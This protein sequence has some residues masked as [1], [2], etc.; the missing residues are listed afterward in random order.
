MLG[1]SA[2]KAA[3]LQVQTSNLTVNAHHLTGN[4]IPQ[5]LLVETLSTSLH[6]SSG[7]VVCQALKLVT[8]QHSVLQGN[9]LVTYDTST[10]L[11]TLYDSVRITA[12]LSESIIASADLGIFIPYFTIYK[13]SYRF[14]G[15]IEGKLDDLHLKNFKFDL[16]DSG[17]FL[18]GNL[19]LQGLP[20]LK[21]TV[22]NLELQEGHLQVQELLP[23]LDPKHHHLL[24]G[25]VYISPQGHIYG[26]RDD[27]TACTTFSTA[28]GRVST[29]LKFQID[30]GSQLA[31]YKGALAT[32][33][34]ELGKWL[35]S[36]A[37][38]QL[39]MQGQID[40]QGMS[41]D[42]ADFQ[43]EAT[44]DKLGWNNY[45]YQNMN[46]QGAFTQTSFEGKF[47]VNDPNLQCQ[48]DA[49]IDLN[50]SQ[51]RIAV[52][53]AIAR[54]D[55]QALRLTAVP[56]TFNT[57]LSMKLQGLLLDNSQVD[58]QLNGLCLSL[59][60][61]QVDLGA[62]HFRAGQN[63]GKR[64]LALDSSLVALDA[65]GGF[66]YSA[67][68][69]D[70]EHLAQSFQRQFIGD[71]AIPR[72]KRGSPYACAYHI[73]C[74]NINP[75]LS[76]LKPAVYV[77]PGT[78]LEGSFVQGHSST[79][80]LKMTEASSLAF[81]KYTSTDAQLTL[82]AK[83][84]D[85]D[86]S[87]TVQ[88]AARQQQWGTLSTTEEFT[89]DVSWI[90]DR[91]NFGT[92]LVQTGIP[93]QLQLQGRAILLGTTVAL[94]LD[95]ASI[96]LFNQKW[97]IHPQNRITLGKNWTQFRKFEWTS[98]TQQISINGI[99]IADPN[100]VLHVK[101]KNFA[102]DNLNSL[103]SK[104]L[105][106]ALNATAVLRGTLG[107]SHIDSDIS[108]D[109]LTIDS[110][111]IGDFQAKTNWKDSLKRLRLVGQL[112]YSAQQ[113][114]AIQG[115]YE[116]EKEEDSL[117]LVAHLFQAQLAALGP[118][119]KQEFSQL[120]GE[121]TG[122]L[123]ISGSLTSPR[124]TGTASIKNATVKINYLQALYQAQ[125]EL[126]FAD[127]FINVN[128]LNLIDDQQGRA[129]LRGQLAFKDF[130]ELQLDLRG[131]MTRFK[132]L[133]TSSED[134]K[135]FYG[136]SIASGK[137][138]FS[139]P[140]NQLTI[141]IRARTEAGTSIGIPIGK[142][143]NSVPQADFIRFVNDQGEHQA[144]KKPQAAFM[145]VK[146]SMLL[147]I[148]PDA[149]IDIMLN[150]GGQDTIKGRGRGQLKM[151]ADNQGVLSMAGGFEFSEGAY[152]FSLYQ[153]VNKTFTILP[154]SKITWADKPF[155][156]VLDVKA[157]YD[158][159]VAL[160]PLL[161]TRQG[162]TT[163]K[164]PVQVLVALRGTLLSPDMNFQVNFQEYPSNIAV[165]TAISAFRQR[166]TDRLYLEQQVMSLIIFKRFSEDSLAVTGSGTVSR[167]LGELI[168]K[169]LNNL[170]AGLDENLEIETD[171]DL[172]E[173]F[174]G[175]RF[176][177]SRNFL[178]GRLRVSREGGLGIDAE[179]QTNTARILGDWAVEYL[180][181]PDGRLRAK[182]YN[183]QF[184]SSAYVGA[185]RS[186][187]AASGGVSILY[188]RSF[189]HFPG[190][191]IKQWRKWIF[192]D[193]HKEAAGSS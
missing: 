169:Q 160:T 177:L 67:L 19:H 99:L 56:L 170:V 61:K 145:G 120:T 122:K 147:D 40:G 117:Q 9:C 46:V 45:E 166:A 193:K 141:D 37:V 144:L 178:D 89:L 116:P 91:I 54:A 135:D 182:F 30:A 163:E 76:I 81:G 192:G 148:T 4:P 168:S 179:G 134:N 156:G 113:T 102:L 188:I 52:Q 90:N 123:S 154:S 139:G 95:P 183:K 191:S 83:R 165:Q 143:S 100:R 115:F 41:W 119:V 125:G 29:D 131:K 158:Q 138:T 129:A 167:S 11:S 186:S 24:S 190:L 25:L 114:V 153:V 73:H 103:V 97:H 157:T 51:E 27:F 10:P 173:G 124:L 72:P 110:Y 104:P 38:Q 53:G 86:I 132:L 137:L 127:Q 82:Q 13:A 7:Q 35:N 63:N 34:F 20:N 171:V 1:S 136:T 162:L 94:E 142:V 15:T 92:T 146:F 18:Q 22:F 184:L 55:L 98:E 181:T 180:L 58:A 39:T 64:S 149:L 32:G 68:I 59:A 28:L 70:L 69:T 121:L 109:Q 75:L 26:K 17:N 87:A 96:Q 2:Q 31:T 152:N 23:Y 33:G 49:A 36:Q 108:I 187:S 78:R 126:T 47:T 48:A 118:L 79:F 21:K 106:G 150:E 128:K 50:K 133:D 185:E 111:L 140:V 175:V 172:E 5:T 12:Q 107:Q 130:K 62:L 155:E 14:Y 60:D 3:S 80:S 101:V 105:T 6:L 85:K 161:R 71:V 16:A 74:K 43:L 189:N 65:E 159:R 57:K 151:T 84:I 164:Y 88:I 77:A 66:A 176:K 8:P 174:E 112:A 44:I 42:T 93:D